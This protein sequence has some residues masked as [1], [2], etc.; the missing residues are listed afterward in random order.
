MKIKQQ[1]D[2]FQVEEL[3]DVTPSPTGA[4]AFYRM[5]KRGWSTPDALQAVRRRWRIELRR[6]SYGGLKDRHAHTVQYFT[7]AHGPTRDLTHAGVS[8]QYLGQLAK[9]YTSH[10]IRANRFRVTL[11][12]LRPQELMRACQALEEVR[13]DGLPNYFDDQRFGSVGPGR[14]FVAEAL[15]RGDFEE[16]LKRALTAPYEYDQAEQ[17][18]E[19]AIL[20]QH[21]GD[22]STCCQQLP[23]GHARSLV[24]YL[25][26]HPG[27][28]RGAVARLRPELRGLY[29]SAYQSYLWNRMLA[30]WLCEHC[31]PEQLL[32]VRLRLGPLPMHRGLDDRQRT[33]LAALRLP[34]PSARLR[35]GDADPRRPLVD[36]V[37]A[38]EGLT[39]A[40]LKVPGLRAPFFSKGERAAL[41]R[42]A[43]LSY[44][45][46]T[47]DRHPG[48]SKLILQFELPRGSYAT[49][50]IKRISADQTAGDRV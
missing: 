6:L 49:L 45:T 50:I 31:R 19:K 8:I 28:F 27:D 4:Y 44:E 23:R 48:K 14:K 36:A 18:R 22:W 17:K 16:A 26:H 34:L 40:E 15:V 29:L 41:C 13:H 39:L 37:L 12:A 21:W 32:M 3:T 1:P 42:V 43:G 11:R 10:D 35:L 2:D 9:P 30:R 38:E 46:A 20:R 5:E 24:D 47:D 33:A 25:A 7:I